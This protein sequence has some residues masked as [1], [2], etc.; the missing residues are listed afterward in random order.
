VAVPPAPGPTTD[1]AGTAP[2]EAVTGVR[3]ALTG[4]GGADVSAADGPDLRLAGLALGTWLATVLALRVPQHAAVTLA[5]ASGLGAAVTALAARVAGSV[6]DALPRAPLLLAVVPFFVGGA[7]GS[8]ATAARTIARDAGPVRELVAHHATVHAELTLTSDPRLSRGSTPGRQLWVVPATVTRLVPDL[9]GRAAV[10]LSAPALILGTGSGWQGLLPGQ[11]VAVTGRLSQPQERDLTVAVLSVRAPPALHGRPPWYQRLAGRLRA[12]LQQA[13]AG[14]PVQPGGLLPGLVDGDTSRM[15]PRVRRDF[16]AAGMTY[17]VVVAGT[18]LAIALGCVLFLARRGR[19]GPRLVAGIGL[20]AVAG[21]A[22]LAR[23]GPSVARGAMMA[24]LGLFAVAC[25]RPKAA[26]PALAAAVFLLLM[27]NPQFAVEVGFT[28]STL[29]T[30]GLLLLV[31]AWRERLC[32]RGVRPGM[33]TAVA[34][35]LAAQLA[36]APVV[37]AAFGMVGVSAVPA[38]MLAAPALEPTMVL[39]LGATAL[40]PVSP[41]AAHALAW[42]AAWPCRWMVEVARCAARV[43]G[44]V[45]PWPT[46]L[47]GGVLL[48]AL[49]LVAVALCA[50]RPAFVVVPVTIELVI[51][52]AG[53]V[54]G[55]PR[56]G[57]PVAIAPAPESRPSQCHARR[58]PLQDPTCTPGA[59]NPSVTPNTLAATICRPGW[60]ATIRPPTSYTNDLK[61]RQIEQYGYLD[62]ALG[63]YEEDHLVPLSLGGNPTDPRNLWPEPGASPNTKDGVEADLQSAVCAHQV[64]LASAQQAVAADWTT[65]ERRLG[66]G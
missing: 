55:V 16:E 2:G 44:G 46:G 37:A 49:L 66:I 50:Q 34:V 56:T 35:P 47:V 43:P 58:G 62:Q 53:G 26:L 57:R 19:L 18:H 32:R 60:T 52:A 38:N 27:I 25:G 42:I 13:C 65:A 8:I 17:L 63:S 59:L 22:V 28:L 10:R 12:G 1:D 14:L 40:S 24:A 61:R 64:S 41:A 30:A 39:G 33:A 21:F 23:P 3:A 6:V 11:R 4:S 51:L 54:S 7:C 29:A 45:L 20:V 31:P 5:A 48:T 15:D 9:P 36:C